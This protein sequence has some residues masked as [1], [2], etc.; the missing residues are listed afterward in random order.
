MQL[1]FAEN[2]NILLVHLYSEI[3][4]I[5]QTEIMKGVMSDVKE[6]FIVK[7]TGYDTPNIVTIRS[8]YLAV[9]H[10][11][12]QLTILLYLIVWVFIYNHGYQYID[13]AAVSAVTSKVKGI[14]HSASHDRSI[15]DRIWDT[16]DL[17]VPPQQNGAFFLMTNVIITSNQ[18]QGVCPELR[19]NNA[20]C[21]S[22]SEC[23]PAGEPYHL[24]HGLSTGQCHRR[25]GTCKVKIGRA[26]CRERV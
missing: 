16:A 13:K 6:Y 8:R 12:E 18:S 20:E 11:V 21:S 23:L 4:W 1:S 17:V 7:W 19:E 2:R 14:S 26:S 10:K 24:G 3:D 9:L 15:A 25:T 5:A 22:D